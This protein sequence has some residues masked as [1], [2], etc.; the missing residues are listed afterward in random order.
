MFSADK[1]TNVIL[2]EWIAFSWVL[3]IILRDTF[4]SL[5]AIIPNNL[6]VFILSAIILISILI[7]AFDSILYFRHIPLKLYYLSVCFLLYFC[8]VFKP[9]YLPLW[10]NVIA[11]IICFWIAIQ[12]IRGIWTQKKWRYVY[13][14]DLISNVKYL[15]IIWQIIIML[16]I[17]DTIGYNPAY[18]FFIIPTI[19]FMILVYKYDSKKITIK[20]FY[21]IYFVNL[22]LICL[23]DY[24]IWSDF[25]KHFPVLLMLPICYNL[26]KQL[27]KKKTIIFLAI[28]AAFFE[29]FAILRIIRFIPE[30]MNPYIAIIGLILNIIVAIA[31]FV[32]TEK[33]DIRKII[34]PFT[35]VYTQEDIYE[36]VTAY[37]RYIDDN[38]FLYGPAI[39]KA[40]EY[41]DI[42]GNIVDLIK[43]KAESNDT[44]FI[45]VSVKKLPVLLNML[46]N[47]IWFVTRHWRAFAA[48]MLLMIWVPITSPGA[49]NFL[50]SSLANHGKISIL[51]ETV[52]Y[53]NSYG[54][55][56]LNDLSDNKDI[57]EN[58]SFTSYIARIMSDRAERYLYEGNTDLSIEALSISLFYKNDYDTLYKRFD[59]NYFANNYYATVEDIIALLQFSE[60]ENDREHLIDTK[61]FLSL[62]HGYYE[63]ALIAAQTLNSEFPSIENDAW[64][65]ACLIGNGKPREAVRI[66]NYCIEIDESLP[67]WAYRM[68][69]IAYISL[70]ENGEYDYL[71]NAKNDILTAYNGSK[72][73]YNILAYARLCLLLEDYI[74]AIILIEN[75]IDINEN[76][77]KVYYW[78]SRYYHQ[79]QDY[80]N[81]EIALKK[82]RDLHYIGNGEY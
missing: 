25:F 64:V 20:I 13:Q 59:T 22:F 80:E 81:S 17:I 57:T 29:L 6:V 70:V 55:K 60:S 56:M 5:L 2:L 41:A 69:G 26:N 82:S 18:S 49:Y 30:S 39:I 45:K 15:L 33:K 54:I 65:G 68:R 37:L 53:A 11:L 67:Y 48:I 10:I 12:I 23:Y 24:L 51:L 19:V 75:A 73:L 78:L 27:H 36:Q 58:E 7:I 63:T 16:D 72:S 52:Y 9:S 40:V 34:L 50:S 4:I 77:G 76:S 38:K 71:D 43:E 32:K 21:S 62:Y 14:F 61:S 46:R 1:K 74:Q 8:I 47:I 66:L 79:I 3:A 28:I 42:G 35:G 44:I 31:L